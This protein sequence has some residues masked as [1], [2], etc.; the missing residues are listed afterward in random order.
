MMEAF[1]QKTDQALAGMNGV[2]HLQQHQMPSVEQRLLDKHLELAS[3]IRDHEEV[4]Q[5]FA[6]Y[7]RNA[8]A[9]MSRL[10]R[11]LV[12][13]ERRMDNIEWHARS[14]MEKDPRI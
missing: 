11:D 4:M 9:E 2:H 14:V 7:T 13:A 12:D 5:G 3:A 8:A 10:C 6:I 1:Q